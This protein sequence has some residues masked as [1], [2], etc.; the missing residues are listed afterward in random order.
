MG[1]VAAPI[2]GLHF[3][4]DLLNSLKKQGMLIDYITLHVGY[5]TFNPVKTEK[6]EDHVMHA[7]HFHI[8]DTVA[9]RLSEHKMSKALLGAVGTTSTRTLESAWTGEAFKSG[10]V[11]HLCLFIQDIGLKVWI[12]W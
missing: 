2:A 3:T 7:E 8:E 5:G 11:H 6:V 4:P 9:K 10:S 12:L 1:S